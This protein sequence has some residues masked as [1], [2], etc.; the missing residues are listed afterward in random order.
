MENFPGLPRRPRP[1]APGGRTSAPSRLADPEGGRAGCSEGRRIGAAKQLARALRGHSGP[2]RG[3]A[4]ASARGE[5]RQVDE[6]P[7]HRPAV[8]AGSDGDRLETERGGETGGLG[9]QARVETL[10]LLGTDFLL[11]FHTAGM[12]GNFLL[13]NVVF[14]SV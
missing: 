11:M 2:L 14:P 13:D 7:L 6:L 3:F 5:H 12:T 8:A 9:N 1:G 4:G 10:R